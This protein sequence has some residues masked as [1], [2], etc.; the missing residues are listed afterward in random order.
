MN[1]YA[2]AGAVIL[3]LFI[4]LGWFAFRQEPPPLDQQPAK[5]KTVKPAARLNAPAFE[6]DD[7]STNRQVATQTDNAAITNAADLYRQA[8]ALYGALTNDDKDILRDWHTNVDASVEAEL[9]EK[10]RAICDLMHQASAVTNCDWGVEPITP[11]T[12]LTH[13][14]ASRN[15]ARAALWRAAHCSSN[16]ASGPTDDVLSVLRLGHSVSRSMILGCLVDIGLQNL[17]AAYVAENIG[18]FSRPDSQRLATA[19]GD[20]INTEA[21]SDAVQQEAQMH[22]RFAAKLASLPEA[23]AEKAFS[24][25]YSW[26]MTPPPT[27]GKAP[28]SNLNRATA[29]TMLTQLADSERELAKALASSSDDEYEAWLKHSTELQASNALGMLLPALTQFVDKVR[30][31]E[32]NRALVAAGLAFAQDGASALSSHPDPSSGQPFVYTKT[33][34]G[35]QLQST[36]QVNGKPLTMQ[37]KAR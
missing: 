18:S 22:E 33:D 19:F 26:V 16:D 27:W 34:D 36:Y 3:C 31:A 5:V 20:P 35:F 14:A 25:Q 7:D 29:L 28:L 13:L 10:I 21:P 4:V 1:R 15:I 24:D 23:E 30:S 12:K 37:F 9:C 8:F 6:S 17:A 11:D 2:V 32:V